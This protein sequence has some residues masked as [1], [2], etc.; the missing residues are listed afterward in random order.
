MIQAAPKQESYE[1][2]FAKG[3]QEDA[4]AFFRQNK[5]GG[6]HE[7]GNMGKWGYSSQKDSSDPVCGGILWD[8]FV[9]LHPGYYPKQNQVRLVQENLGWLHKLTGKIDGVLDFG[10]GSPEAIHNYAIPL[11]KEFSEASFYMPI[12]TCEDFVN[13]A[14]Q[15]VKKE[16]GAQQRII[17]CHCDFTQPIEGIPEGKKLGLFLGSST[18]F[19]DFPDGM[20]SLL[21]D[22]RKAVG[23][24]GYLAM[25]FDTNTD[26]QSV[27]V[28]YD[29]PIHEQ[30]EINLIQLLKRDLNIT[31][32]L[33]PSAWRYE[34][35]TK[36][37]EFR[38]QKILVTHHVLVST[39]PQSF[40]I[41]DEHISIGEGE[42][43]I[44]DKSFKIPLQ[45]MDELAVEEGYTPVGVRF[46]HQR[47][48]AMPVYAVN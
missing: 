33:D 31:G 36:D 34:T 48:L 39:R 7:I 13:G 22:F 32:D 12:D 1:L 3:L 35:D 45:V 2:E 43:L 18:N 6:K 17:P 10:S 20:R 27:I 41:D 46:D 37:L 44:A 4:L 8:L 29:H 24:G 14:V 9:L 5:L 16:L 26:R 15:Q 30:M 38:G 40:F 19:Q 47:R 11:L 21:Q 42:R 28:S 25:S 23:K